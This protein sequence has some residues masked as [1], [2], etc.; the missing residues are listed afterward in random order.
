MPSCIKS[1]QSVTLGTTNPDI[2]LSFED[3]SAIT[4]TF[5]VAGHT[6]TDVDYIAD[7]IRT[8]PTPSKT[9]PDQLTF[10][11]PESAVVDFT[12]TVTTSTNPTEGEA[13][14]IMTPAVVVLK[15]RTTCPS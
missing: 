9:P 4:I 7:P 2:F 8:G 11:D 13:I 12:L 10:Y 14:G 3:N 15:P 1:S 6:V 5:I